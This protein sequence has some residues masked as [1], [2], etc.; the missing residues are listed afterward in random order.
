MNKHEVYDDIRSLCLSNFVFSKNK[1]NYDR[2]KITSFLIDIDETDPKSLKVLILL[3][4]R[5]RFTKIPP[6]LA[7]SYRHSDRENYI[8]KS[9]LKSFRLRDRQVR[10]SRTRTLRGK[11]Q[12][13]ITA[14]SYIPLTLH[15]LA[16]I[17]FTFI[18][19]EDKG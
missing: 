9:V 16:C 12:I 11:V 14:L 4:S 10:S 1:E 17:Y 18:C 2:T 6:C 13:C 7:T 19:R 5:M 3:I 15:S 8:P